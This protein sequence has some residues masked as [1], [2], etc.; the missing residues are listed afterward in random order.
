MNS[1]RC[2]VTIASFLVAAGCTD[3]TQPSPRGP[4]PQAS[5]D[6]SAN[7]L[8]QALAPQTITRAN[9][10]PQVISFTVAGF[11]PQA[12][13][14]VV[15]GDASG[16]NRATSGDVTL[17]GTPVVDP[18]RFDK[19]VASFDVPF[20]LGNPSTLSVRLTGSPGSTIVISVDAAG[21]T[22]AQVPAGGGTAQFDAGQITLTIPAGALGSPAMLSA[23]PIAPDPTQPANTNV[24]GG[25]AVELGPEGTQFAQPITIGL[26]YDPTRLPN[27]FV[28]AALRLGTFVNGQWQEIKGSTVDPVTH[29]VTGQTTH[30]STYGVV[31]FETFSQVSIGGGHVCGVTPAQDIYC[32]GRNQFGELGS[33][34][35]QSC[36]SQGGAPFPCTPTPTLVSGGI[37]FLS[38]TAGQTHTCGL[39]VSGDAYCWG[40][41]AEGALGD[42]SLSNQ[43]APTLVQGGFHFSYVGAGGEVT[44]GL[45]TSGAAYCWGSNQVGGLGT[46]TAESC[47]RVTGA[48]DPGV[49]TVGCSTV[50]IAVSDGRTFTQLSEGL[51]NA[52]GLALDHVA[53]CWGFNASGAVGD[54]TSINRFSPVPIGGGL[55]FRELSAGG[56]ASCGISGQTAL[57]WG[58]NQG[59]QLLGIGVAPDHFTPVAV[60]GGLSFAH[61]AAN[62]ANDVTE[63]LCGLTTTGDI[64]CWGGNDA[65]QLGF[66]GGNSTC[67]SGT[68]SFPCQNVPTQVAIGRTYRSVVVGDELTCATG[69]DGE[70]YCFGN[71]QFG[72]I[73]DGTVSLNGIVTRVP[74][75]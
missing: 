53:W 66:A 18:S 17:D 21:A 9:G 61:V 58:T 34:S 27:G 49:G 25:S 73:G 14:H 63:H 32:W 54:G 43:P 8:F 65:Q 41:G 71:D 15:N 59:F 51:S 22:T 5:R 74:R 67:G 38:V 7:Q 69:T 40:A 47:P 29:T 44:C 4:T 10:E 42:G 72:Q 68:F 31:A 62:T 1:L 13:L 11:G 12:V 36:A 35:A 19:K 75:P 56:L 33:P 28:E 70:T 45:T 2:A 60:S 26:R 52:C 16:N 39:A 46:T 30:F 24:V 20:S 57:C 37:K 64:W 3:A 48:G 23:D 55:Q 50:P 6:A